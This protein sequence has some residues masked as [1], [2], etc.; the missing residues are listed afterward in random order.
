MPQEFWIEEYRKKAASADPILQSGRGKQFDAVELLYVVKQ[1]V[2]L[3]RLDA[4]HELL[5]VGCGNGLLDIVLSACCRHVMAIEPVEELAEL[6]R[7]NLR[8]CPNVAVEVGH[9]ADIRAANDTFDCMLAFGVLQ[10]VSPEE[11]IEMFGEAVRVVRPGG[12]VVFG[13]ILDAA[14]RD[15]FLI[16]YLDGVRGGSHLSADEKEEIIRRNL[17]AHWHHP[18]DLADWWMGR[19]CSVTIHSLVAGDP[20]ADHRFHLVVTVEKHA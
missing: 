16:P 14:R 19:G 10:L 7:K 17:S 3:L 6:A 9:G 20:D 5:D 2:E 11:A 13:S 1:V 15:R 12:R 18:K 8:H 4:S